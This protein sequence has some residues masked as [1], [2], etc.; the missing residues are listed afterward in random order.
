[1]RKIV[2]VGGGF[3]GAAVA[4][5]L[6]RRP[7][8]SGVH[9]V[10]VERR[11]RFGRGLAYSTWDD[12]HILNVPAGNM[13]LHPDDPHHFV[14][15]CQEQDPA[16]GPS[17]FVCR[18]LYG[19]YIERELHAAVRSSHGRLELVQGEV[20]YIALQP[21]DRGATVQVEGRGAV[22]SSPLRA[23]VV[24]L[25]SGHLEPS[26]I[27]SAE[28]NADAGSC[29]DNPWHSAAF[30][31]LTAEDPVAIVGTG[32]TAI[33]VLFSLSGRSEARRSYLISRHGLLPQPHRT[34][35]ILGAWPAFPEYLEQAPMT[36]R[37]CSRALRCQV[38]SAALRGIDWRDIIGGLRPHTPEIWRRLPVPERERFMKWLAPYWNVHRHRLA[39]AAWNRLAGMIGRGSVEVIAGRIEA[40]ERIE[41]AVRLTVAPRGGRTRRKLEVRRVINCTGAGC[42]LLGTSDRL[43]RQLLAQG[44]VRPDPLR[45]GLN[46]SAHYRVV[47][48]SG[49]ACNS[50]RYIGPML[51][52]TY[53]EAIAVPELRVHARRLAENLVQPA[54]PG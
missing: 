31:G 14:H 49:R 43:V 12:N 20:S 13:S 26:P 28:E 27:V 33:D 51:R 1:M 17:S 37:A 5:N 52:A 38:K 16:F 30:D 29:V 25:A 19:D 40:I 39:P 2:I 36:A 45:M 18:R 35:A 4:I 6:L 47:G 44:L 24:V 23:D 3:S 46:V 54:P 34:Q 9:V 11:P 41:R 53:G 42:D 21:E 10:M 50:I 22:R 32:H 8:E 48:A 7:P 15:F